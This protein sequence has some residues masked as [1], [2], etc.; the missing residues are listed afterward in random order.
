MDCGR[1]RK[2]PLG[3]RSIGDI[4]PAEVL[5]VLKSIEKTGRLK[6]AKGTRQVIGSVYQLA[7]LTD[8]A[9][10]NPAIVLQRTQG[11][12]GTSGAL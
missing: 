4:R 12:E 7:C 6:A 5:N 2:P 8:R 9:T 11:T 1:P 3:K 10:H